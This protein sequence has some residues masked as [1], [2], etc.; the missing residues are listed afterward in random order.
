M[1]ENDFTRLVAEFEKRRDQEPIIGVGADSVVYRSGGLVLKFYF[2]ELSFELLKRYV[3][4][5]NIVARAKIT[6][7]RSL[8]NDFECQVLS[9]EDVVLSPRGLPVS[10]AKYIDG[11]NLRQEKKE[12]E[13][14][15][16]ALS[17]LD[18]EVRPILIATGEWVRSKTGVRVDICTDNVKRQGKKLLIT[19][20]CARIRTLEEA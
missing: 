6:I 5:T 14:G 15:L 2:D 19:D 12:H 13:S 9:Y 10:I 8:A 20:L 4:L 17:R 18:Y 7:P 1:L 16:L 3:E 11:P